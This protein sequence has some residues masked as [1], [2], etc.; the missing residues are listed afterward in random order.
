LCAPS[1]SQTLLH[2]AVQEAEIH[3]VN[4][5]MAVLGSTEQRDD[6][7]CVVTPLD[8]K[9]GFDL[10][11]QAGY[12]VTIPLAEMA[13]SGT[14]L[15]VL[16][17][18]TPLDGKNQPHYFVDRFTVPSIEA[19][20]KGDAELPG[21]YMLGPGRYRVDWLM[22]DRSERVCSSHWT[23]ETAT[24]EE[25]EDLATTPNAYS[26][27]L[28]RADMFLEEPPVQRTAMHSSLHVKLLVNF[29]PTDPAD[30]QLQPYDLEN[31]VSILRA[32]S[33]EPQIGSFSLVA[34]N[35]QEERVIFEEHAVTRIDF[36]GLGESVSSI[37]GGVIDVAKLQDEE[38]GPRFLTSL[39]REHLGPQ[40]PEPDA[41][42]FV[43]PKLVLEKKI[44]GQVL[45]EG[46]STNAPI[47][48]LI[49]NRNP[50]SFPWRDALSV[51]LKPHKAL[52]YTITL[53][54]DFGRAMKDMMLRLGGK[55]AVQSAAEQSQPAPQPGLFR[56]P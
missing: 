26:V 37:A 42:I 4:T 7:P 3:I 15:R 35:M 43:G 39:I 55:P 29:T 17:R 16:F 56:A 18:I 19:G 13:G 24:A 25:F 40:Q 22:R 1:F 34:F 2:N 31:I 23:V 48:Y 14:S 47:F 53:P 8:P 9:L 20:A 36:P 52:E 50:R 28:R 27:G 30:A 44:S 12:Y 49:Y 38:S 11:F 51:L 6:L 46:E 32:I 54:R 21:R 33:R 41:V 45:A 10:Q 5:D